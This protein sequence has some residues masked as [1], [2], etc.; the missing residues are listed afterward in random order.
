MLNNYNYFIT[1]AEELNISRA[2]EKLFISHQCLS[3]YLKNLESEYGIPLFERTPALKLTLAGDGK[4]LP[5]VHGPTQKDTLAARHLR[6]CVK[7]MTGIEPRLV[8]AAAAKGVEKAVFVVSD[9]KPGDESFAVTV[10]FS[11]TMLTLTRAAKSMQQT[12]PCSSSSCSARSLNSR[13]QSVRSRITPLNS[14]VSTC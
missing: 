12:L 6:D 14:R 11:R 2:A 10:Q 5:I 13:S 1:L 4:A 7:E 8:P 9:A 3:K